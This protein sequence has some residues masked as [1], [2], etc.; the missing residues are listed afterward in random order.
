MIE[1][2]ESVLK[3]DYHNYQVMVVDN[4]S[5]NNSMKYIKTWVER[6]LDIGIKTKY[7][8]IEYTYNKTSA[9]SEVVLSNK[10][11]LRLDS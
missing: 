10:K 9:I 6:K 7:F 1:C 3:N 2:L 8:G 5:P 11:E 4:N